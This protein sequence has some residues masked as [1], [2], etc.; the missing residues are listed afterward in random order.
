MST[1]D[2]RAAVIFD[3]ARRE[4]DQLGGQYARP[5]MER[6]SPVPEPLDQAIAADRVLWST[7]MRARQNLA[8]QIAARLEKLIPRDDVARFTTA[9]IAVPRERFVL[10]EDI[11]TSD[12]DAPS[13]LDQAGLATV[14]A[15][16]AY[17]L[18]YA[19]LGLGE[20]DHLVELG[21]GTG[22][23]AA[24]ASHVVGPTGAV[25][26]IEIDPVLH[27]RARR[28]LASSDAHG[29]API[30]LIPGD[31]AALAPDV[32]ARVAADSRPIRVAVTYAL[33]QTPEAILARLPEGGR[34]VA[35]VG[36][37]NEDQR[38]LSWTREHGALRQGSHGAVRYVTERR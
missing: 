35:P 21:T 19:L 8:L 7:A 36:A 26:S 25:T 23:G 32:L 22:Y 2:G 14:S 27:E 4:L 33:A 38:L 5:P 11:G 13:P 17:V 18:T 1:V 20:G 3:T 12:D 37:G 10:P 15:P 30:T 29:S 31:A 28:L 24:L 16:H 6:W 9:L 34:L